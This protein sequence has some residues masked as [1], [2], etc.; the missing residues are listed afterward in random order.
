LYKKLLHKY[1]HCVELLIWV[2]AKFTLNFLDLPT[3]SSRISKFEIIS[4]IYLNK[5][6]Q[7]KASTSHGSNPAHGLGPSG[8]AACGA[9]VPRP[10]CF[11]SPRSKRLDLR[12]PARGRSGAAWH[13][14]TLAGAASSGSLVDK[15]RQGPRLKHHR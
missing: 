3:S 10:A 14:R 6:E 8:V 9:G 1:S 7:E 5:K 12:G 4:R 13:A 15:K 11:P 2:H